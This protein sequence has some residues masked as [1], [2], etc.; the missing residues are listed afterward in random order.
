MPLETENPTSRLTPRQLQLLKVICSFQT[1]QCYSP[2]LAELASELR[3]SRSTVFEHI[4]ELR[5][6]GLLSAY[7]G[8]A[9]SLNPTSKAQKLLEA[10]T[11]RSSNSHHK[12]MGI[13]LVGKVAAGLPIEAIEDKDFLS[14]ASRF[15]TG[16]DL[17]AL[18]VTGDSMVDDDIRD[19]D[20]V[21][22][23]RTPFANNGQLV[24]AILDK[25]EATLKRFYRQ[26]SNARLQPA[27]ADFH[28]IYSDN[29]RIEAVVIGLLRKF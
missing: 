14:L 19:G 16:D 7:P 29:C 21:I 11:D 26:K 1:S 27:N 4:T 12:P 28:P 10:L 18:Q 3:I 25:K 20:F 8:R 13:P 23:R 24:I 9:R 2:T 15:G 6:K 5:K 22:C 17:F